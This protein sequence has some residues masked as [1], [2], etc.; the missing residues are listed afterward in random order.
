MTTPDISEVLREVKLSGGNLE[1]PKKPANLP[2]GAPG[3]KSSWTDDLD[4]ELN[5]F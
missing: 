5:K 2:N 1:D 3:R 4:D